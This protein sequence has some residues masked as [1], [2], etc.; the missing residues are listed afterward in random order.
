MHLIR[1]IFTIAM[2]AIG[3]TLAAPRLGLSPLL[4]LLPTL[5]AL[6]LHLLLVQR[7]RK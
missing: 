4:E 6:H 7:L 5:L 1:M 3:T 2:I